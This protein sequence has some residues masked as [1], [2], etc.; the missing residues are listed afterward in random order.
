MGSAPNDCPLSRALQTRNLLLFG[1]C[2]G[3][4]YLTAPVGYVGITQAPLCRELGASDAVANLPQ[5]IYLAMTAAP[6]LIAWAI[7]YV[8]WLKRN[9]VLCYA[10]TAV[11]VAAVPLTL[12]APVSNAVKI[13]AVILHAA[14]HGVLSP[15]AVM[16]LWEVIG[17]GL[18]ATRRGPA[19]ALAFGVGPLLAF[20][21]S[22]ASQLLLKGKLGSLRLPGLDFPWN[23]AALYAAAV[24]ILAG[25]ALLCTLFV[26]PQPEKDAV[27]EPFF[28]GVFGGVVNVLRDRVLLTAT[29]VTILVYTGNAIP[30]NMGLY[31]P[32]VLG[33]KA[34]DY[35]GKENA[36]RFAFK[37]VTGLF[38]GWLLTRTTPRAGIVVTTALGVASLAWALFAP[39]GWYLV[40]FGIYGA[41]ELVGVYC[42][43][44]ILTAS[45]RLEMRRNMAFATLLMVPA[46]PVGYVFGA[47]SDWFRARG[48]AA[49][50]YQVTFATCAAVMVAGMV[51]ALLR[52]PARPRPEPPDEKGPP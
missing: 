40:A 42:P 36:Y 35:A 47:M 24:P 32:E 21:A 46:A 9:L 34:E 33:G 41:G 1:A 10:L 38:L 15:A 16:F 30:S 14:V 12:L 31:A 3:A 26:V 18:T 17:R 52:L 27:R 45:R 48:H 23:F 11:A 2:I 39:P 20:A 44:Y 19:L 28:A 13:R 50:G 5:S 49:E 22:L 29:I 37:A 25:T 8:A 7:P 51:L 6:V 4:N 43:N